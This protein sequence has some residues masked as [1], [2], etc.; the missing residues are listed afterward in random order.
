MN[1][2]IRKLIDIAGSEVVTREGAA[3]IPA[4]ELL[5]TKAQPGPDGKG[6]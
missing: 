6:E 4:R 5:S 2:A 3:T 1:D